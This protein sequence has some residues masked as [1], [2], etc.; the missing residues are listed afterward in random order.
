MGNLKAQLR[1]YGSIIMLA[2]RMVRPSSPS[3][4][5]SPSY[6][7]KSQYLF[8]LR[9]KTLSCIDIMHYLPPI[10]IGLRKNPLIILVPLCMLVHSMRNILREMVFPRE[11]QLYKQTCPLFYN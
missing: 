5:F 3:T 2:I 10:V 4:L 6:T 9:A 8:G 7:I 1:S 11:N